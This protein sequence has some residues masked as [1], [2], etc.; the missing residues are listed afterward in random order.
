MGLFGAPVIDLNNLYELELSTP[1]LIVWAVPAMLFFAAL[2]YGISLY[3]HRK[4]YENK[5]L[6]GS[7]GV[8]LG[9]LL[10]SAALKF[11]LLYVIV[12]SYNQLPWRMELNWWT[13]LPCYI[14]Y[15]FFSY[16]AHRVSHEQRFWWATHV[17]HHS[18]DYYNLA[19]SFRLSWVQHIKIVFLIPVL[20]MGFH[21]IIFFVTNQVAVLFQFWVHTEYIRKM[22]PIIEYI[23][24]TPSNHRVHHGSQD[25][26]LDKN[27]GATFILWDRMFGTY[28]PEEEQV[29]YGLTTPIKNKANPFF[30]NFH[31]YADM[32]TDV[33]NAKGLKRKLYYIFGS[34]ARIAK[35]KLQGQKAIPMK[36]EPSELPMK[37]LEE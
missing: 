19:V 12:W 2:E 17:V 18:G 31:E 28:Q 22:H 24:A 25:K 34:P 20:L 35:E 4:Y 32:W 37:V 3:Q 14:I 1:N 6:L 23:F 7:I 29:V 33:R 5:E 13:W 30:I 21:P 11:V 9:N 26:Y 16:W 15:D 27:Y 10:V 8:G 36:K